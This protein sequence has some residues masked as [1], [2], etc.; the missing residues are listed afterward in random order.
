MNA[1]T[2]ATARTSRKRPPP[3]PGQPDK[4]NAIQKVCAILRVLA[5]RS[6]LRLTDIADTTSLNKATALRILNSLIEEGFVSRVAG[7][8]TYELGQEARVMAVGAR[9]SVDIAELAQPSLLR[10][11]ERSADTALL[12]VRSGVEAL[13]LARSVGSHPLQP[14]Y[15]QIGSRRPL[16]VGAGALALL[17]WLPDAEIEAV[18][19][20]IVPRLAKSPRITPKFLRERIAVARKAGHT[21]LLDAA[22]PGMGGVGVPVRDDAGEVVAALSIGAA[23]D[24]IRRRESELADM[25]KKEAQVL[26]RAMAQAPKN[27]RPAK[28]G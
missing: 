3:E 19:E 15:L 16:G 25:L 24:R 10:L 26:A 28:A 21:V 4:F 18:I 1:S 12:S 9:R 7:A 17:V 5:Q 22:F 6:P 11:S 2:T 23:T 20:V 14:N 27:G 8:K 13:Y